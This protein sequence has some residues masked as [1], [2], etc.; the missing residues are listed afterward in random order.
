MPRIWTVIVPLEGKPDDDLYY[1]TSLELVRQSIA[2][3]YSSAD[4]PA[5]LELEE[6]ARYLWHVHGIPIAEAWAVDIPGD[7]RTQPTHF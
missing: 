6:G 5:E 7:V 2:L 4:K 3:T 1:F